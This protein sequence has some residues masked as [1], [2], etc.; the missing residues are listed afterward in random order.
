MEKWMDGCYINVIC[1]TSTC[2]CPC[3]E[4]DK[5]SYNEAL[6]RL[7]SPEEEGGRSSTSPHKRVHEEA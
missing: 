7:K 6:N 3:K 4:D 5:R 2:L 1:T